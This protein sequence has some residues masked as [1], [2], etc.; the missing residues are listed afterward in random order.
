M[1]ATREVVI[2]ADSLAKQFKTVKKESGIKGAVK[3]LFRSEKSIKKA[4][5]DVSFEIKRGEIVGYIGPNGAGK[6]TTIKMMCGILNPTSGEI[7]INGKSPVRERQKVVRDLGVVF[8]QRSQLYWDLRLGESFELL[9][10]IYEVEKS[11]FDERM[12]E[13]DA[14]LNIG[15]F[16][17]KPVRQLSLGQ[18]MR[19][20]LAASML[21]SPSI[22]FLDEPTIGLD[23]EVKH[24]VRKFI[25]EINAKYQTTIILT[26]HDL[27]DIQA[28][29]ERIIIINQ[30]KII[31]DCSLEEL[32]ETSLSH[33]LLI[34]DT[35]DENVSFS[36]PKAEVSAIGTQRLQLKFEKN[37]I[38]AAEL[39][40]ELSKVC[41]VKDLQIKEADINDV[42]MQIYA[43]SSGRQAQD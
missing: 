40:G 18:R 25:K 2:K 33:R 37:A 29:C 38:S 9:R 30:G 13:L 7:L 21:H 42:I 31:S 27:D 14:I 12:R 8:G 36:H 19:G 15:E 39:I 43:N 20:D 34:A 22:L 28:L 11:A 32:I 4:V 1:S 23:V 3:N 26:T 10:R 16:I 24:S 17:D 41:L 6:S 35:Y 5:D